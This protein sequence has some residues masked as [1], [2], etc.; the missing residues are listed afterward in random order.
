MHDRRPGRSTPVRAA[1]RFAL[2]AIVIGLTDG[3]SLVA[4]AS[5]S[6]S[7]ASPSPSEE[8]PP[9]P[10]SGV[11]VWLDEPLP[12][13]AE[14]GGRLDIGAVIWS[15]DRHELVETQGSYLRLYPLTGDAEP[16]E[17]RTRSD[18]PGHVR[19]T[20]VVPEGG[21][22]RVE[23]GFTG[24][25]CHDDGTCQ[26]VDFPFEAGGV[27]PPPEASRALLVQAAFR[28]PVEELVAGSAFELA[29]DLRPR[30][31][32]DPELLALPERLVATASKLQGGIVLA[33]AELRRSAML[34]TVYTGSLAI[35]EPGEVVLRAA[36]P[37]GLEN[38]TIASSTT[39]LRIAAGAAGGGPAAGG[40]GE[41]AVPVPWLVGGA[42]LVLLGG[43]VIRK[44]F[45]DL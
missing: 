15:V 11:Q 32:W 40:A 24:E 7:V 14:P 41:P 6:P 12:Q 35:P 37:G 33:T 5:P 19:A 42:V 30:E 43:I 38:Q 44:V 21:A 9:E 8:P 31:H 29:L 20:V 2:I 28:P 13:A 26:E 16:G 27:G 17:A 4:A 23:V 25:E 36:L 34:D 1:A 45:A 18:W 22:G 3:A 10:G 39:R